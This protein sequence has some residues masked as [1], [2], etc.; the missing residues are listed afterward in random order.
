MRGKMSCF[1]D[2]G[3][4]ATTYCNISSRKSPEGLSEAARLQLLMSHGVFG[5]ATTISPEQEQRATA[6]SCARKLILE[7]Y[8]VTA[9]RAVH[10]DCPDH[11]AGQ[12]RRAGRRIGR[13]AREWRM[14]VMIRVR[15]LSDSGRVARLRSALVASTPATRDA[16]V[17]LTR[18]AEPARRVPVYKVIVAEGGLERGRMLRAR[19]GIRSFLVG[20]RILTQEDVAG[21]TRALPVNL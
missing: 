10:A 17:F 12:L 4:T 13:A 3:V 7:P 6:Q 2:A 19:Y 15:N 5:G 16:G 11:H 9:S 20:E 14:D 8:Q 18:T 1:V 21:A